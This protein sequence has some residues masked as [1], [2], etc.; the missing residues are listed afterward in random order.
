MRGDERAIV[1]VQLYL[2]W[3]SLYK[4]ILLCKRITSD[5]FY[6]IVKPVLNQDTFDEVCEELKEKFD[7]LIYSYPPGISNIPIFQGMTW[8]PTWKATPKGAGS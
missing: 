4:V 2:S 5:S 8:V 7:Y 3:F 6:S 1:L